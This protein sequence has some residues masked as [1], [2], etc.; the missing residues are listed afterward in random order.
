MT[1]PMPLGVPLHRLSLPAVA[2]VVVVTVCALLAAVVALLAGSM[3]EVAH[4]LAVAGFTAAAVV[5]HNDQHP[6]ATAAGSVGPRAWVRWRSSWAGAAGS[7]SGG[8]R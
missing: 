2:A 4:R 8:A 7:G 6:P 3:A 1:P 5:A